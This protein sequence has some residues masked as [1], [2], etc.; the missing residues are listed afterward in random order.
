MEDQLGSPGSHHGPLRAVLGVI[1][2]ADGRV[3]MLNAHA[4]QLLQTMS[5][6][7]VG[8][9]YADVFGPSLSDRV[10]RLFLRAAAGWR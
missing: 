1:L 6:E 5:A 10:F 2:D 8:Q 3:T 9:S 4:E 7:A